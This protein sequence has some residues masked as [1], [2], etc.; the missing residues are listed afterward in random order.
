MV[1][2]RSNLADLS[3]LFV[4][5]RTPTPTPAPYPAPAEE[6][7]EEESESLPLLTMTPDTTLKAGRDEVF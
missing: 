6:S 7:G 4:A 2:E 3:G 5:M 1:L